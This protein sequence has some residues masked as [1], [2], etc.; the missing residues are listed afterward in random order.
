MKK[1]ILMPGSR[2]K[3]ITAHLPVLLQAC[4]LLA[5]VVPDVKFQLLVNDANGRELVEGIIEKQTAG[6]LHMEIYEGYQLTHLSQADMACVASGTDLGVRAG[7]SADAGVVP[8][9]S[10]Y[11]FH[12]SAFGEAGRD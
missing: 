5:Q 11:L 10:D 6:C 4:R 3:G 2:R 1:V 8:D 12:R 9:E 7:E